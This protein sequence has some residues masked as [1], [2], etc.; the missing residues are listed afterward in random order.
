MQ[1]AFSQRG[2][3]IEPRSSAAVGIRCN[4]FQIGGRRRVQ[5]HRARAYMGLRCP[6][7]RVS[8]RE[9]RHLIQERLRLP[10][11]HGGGRDRS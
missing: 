10:G 3:S 9:V 8:D 6:T 11:E 2:L 4:A 7:V 1:T 5:A